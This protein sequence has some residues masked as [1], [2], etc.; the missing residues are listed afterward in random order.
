[1][2]SVFTHAAVVATLVAVALRPGTAPTRSTTAIRAAAPLPMLVFLQMPGPGGGGGGGGTRQ[3]KPPARAQAPGRDRVTVPAVAP[4][5]PTAAERPRDVPSALQEVVLDAKPLASGT[6]LLAGVPDASAS[7]T[8]PGG[9]GQG[10]GVGDGTGTGIGSGN[11]S[12]LGPGSRGGFGGGAYRVGNGVVPPRLLTEV[13]PKYTAQALRQQIQG[14]V[15]L[16]AVVSRTG[17]A[18]AI[19][20]VRS[21][22]RGGL[23]DEAIAAVRAWRFAPGRLGQTPVDV[24]VTIYL[25]FRVH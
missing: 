21:L 1:M 10:G 4:R 16:E 12:G 18:T 6:T 13:K 19:R 14:T 5:T 24:L 20:V 3:K 9:P 23:D 22:D 7:M 11:G 17:E 8:A 25:D 2:L 15:V